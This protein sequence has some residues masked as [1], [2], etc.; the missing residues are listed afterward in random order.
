MCPS[1]QVTLEEQ[2]ST[3]GRAHLLWEMLEGDL[4]TD[5]WRSAEVRDAL[6]LCLSCKGCLSD[7]PVNVDMA[8][9]KAEFTYHHYQH[10]PWARPRSH[11]SMGWLPVWARLASYQPSVANRAAGSGAQRLLKRVGG[12]AAQRDLPAFA[13]QSF[14]RWFHG[15]P[16]PVGS[17]SRGRVVLWPDTFT[18]YLE[19]AVA[20][21]AVRVLEAAGFRVHVPAQPVCCGLTWL[22]TGQLGVARRVLRKSLSALRP[23][24]D[25][26]VPIVGLEPSCTAVFRHDAVQLLTGDPLARL[27]RDSTYTL[28]ELLNRHAPDWQPPQVDAAALVQVHCH[29]HS[30]MGFAPDAA[31]MSAAGIAAELPDSG[32]CGVAGNF[33]FEE[34]HIE[35]SRAVGERV[36]L[37]AVREALP[38]TIVI[39]DGFSCRTQIAQE[40]PRRARHLAEVLAGRLDSDLGPKA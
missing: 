3:R 39:A 23:Y 29:Q 18:N 31:L 40:T 22:S 7:C 19:P 27:A 14:V 25:G 34:G 36:L 38:G 20:Q 5:G 8:T 4:I 21:G 10:R 30:V 12:I 13:D 6:D 32:C 24:L 1:Y 17:S 15:R 11:W 16:A 26:G 37:P 35:I 9:Y 2:H 28:A 33:G